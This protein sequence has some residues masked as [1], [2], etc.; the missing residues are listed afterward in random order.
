MTQLLTAAQMQAVDAAALAQGIDSYQLMC[1]AGKAVSDAAMELMSN[2]SGSVLVLAGPGNNGGDGAI[3]ARELK[4][5]GQEV[6]LLKFV[7]RRSAPAASRHTALLN[8]AARA[9][10][11]WDGITRERLLSESVLDQA[12][13]Q[14]I[15]QADLIIDA[16]LGAGLSRPLDGVLASVVERVNAASATV[17]SVDVPTGLDGNS[18]TIQG[19]CIQADATVTFFRC[20][21]AHFL[22]PGRALCG[23]LT[24]AQIGLTEAQL[25]PGWPACRLNGPD[26]FSHALPRLSPQGHKFDR[27]HV[28]V[29]SGPMTSTGASRLSAQ[30]ALA[31]GAGLVTL[32]SPLDALPV[33]AAQLTAVMLTACDDLPQWH[34]LLQDSRINV[35]LA[36][37]GN[38]VTPETQNCVLAALEAD[39]QCVL[40]A[41]ALS[42]WSETAQRELLFRSLDAARQTPV[43]TPH[44]GEF[45]R[46]F[47]DALAALAPVEFPSRLHQAKAAATVASSVVVFKGADTVIAA[48]DGRSAINANAPPWLATAG[49]G[50]VLAGV[51]ASLMAQ[52]MPAFEAACAGV[53][54]HGQAATELGYPMTA[55]QLCRRLPAVLHTTSPVNRQD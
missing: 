28:L 50:D 4:R 40:D 23:Q 51:I 6:C 7:S 42:C 39:L 43:L 29:R 33:N 16:L 2:R 1:A 3:A 31:C 41:D 27:G 44:G 13:L 24:L 36:G 47:S 11:S 8:D 21:P 49:A 14:L 25:D 53:W 45:A 46:L 15:E 9:F 38:G 22:Y 5:N 18:H 48:P 17:L 26:S 20:K 35:A 52:G 10:A 30:T 19:S 54:L 55:E 12:S 34:K 37:P 32:A